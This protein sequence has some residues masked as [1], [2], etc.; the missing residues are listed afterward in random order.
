MESIWKS[1]HEAENEKE[2]QQN[3]KTE[4]VVIGAGLAGILTAYLLQKRGRK[5]IVV[6]AKRIADGQTGNTTAKITSQHGMCYNQL[7]QKMGLKEARGYAGANEDA[8]RC[9][10]RIIKEENIDCDLEKK[11]A[12]LYTEDEKRVKALKKEAEVATSL[13]I[14]ASY[15]EGKQIRELPFQVKGA[16]CFEE[17]AQF[18]PVKFIR[19]LAK[20]MEIY[21]NT[22]VLSVKKH[23]VY[24]NRGSIEAENIVFATHYPI[25]NVPGFYFL[26]QHQ[27][28]SYVLALKEQKELAGMYY[29]IDK[30]SLS[31]RSFGENLLLGG[32]NHR[33]G[34]RGG[35]Y[36]CL[37]QRAEIYYPNAKIGAFWSAQDCMPH[38]GMPFIGKYSSLRPYWYVATG[39]QKWGMTSSMVAAK[40]ISNQIC[41]IS[42]F[43]SQIFSPQR[44]RIRAA[45]KNWLID[46]GESVLGLGKG[47]F[48][49]GKRKCTHLGCR[50]EWNEEEKTWECPCHGSRFDEKGE[51]KDNPSKKDLKYR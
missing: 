27:E 28:R 49:S 2:L 38:D 1:T 45:W 31:F 42:D 24:T 35:K 23:M 8:I 47:L 16:V 11:P 18:H 34:K 5:V 50:L 10:E 51:W 21:E 17:Q 4:T 37:K 43:Y 36:T 3:I 22:K 26:R 39:F 20:D 48:S 41:G 30:G 25:V 12:Y 13:G 7:M 33:T 44:I 29:G 40:I 9:F 19:H 32:G 14:K 46:M 15:I 6:E